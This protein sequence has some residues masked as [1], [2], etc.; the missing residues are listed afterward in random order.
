[1]WQKS[2]IWAPARNGEQKEISEVEVVYVAA[3][4]ES[5]RGIPLVKGW[6]AVAYESDGRPKGARMVIPDTDEERQLMKDGNTEK[7]N[8]I[9]HRNLR[10]RA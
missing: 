10:F 9:Y 3:P 1:M 6:F 5:P 2:I 8:D 7:L 4:A